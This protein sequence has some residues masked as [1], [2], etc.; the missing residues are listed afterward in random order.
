MAVTITN[1]QRIVLVGT[2]DLLAATLWAHDDDASIFH[3]FIRYDKLPQFGKNLRIKRLYHTA[4][5]T[6]F[7]TVL[8]LRANIAPD[9][10]NRSSQAR[11]VFCLLN[12]QTN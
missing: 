10:L 3:Y 6:D 2:H 5:I 8:V 9:K 7:D 1:N 11:Q 12:L 4:D